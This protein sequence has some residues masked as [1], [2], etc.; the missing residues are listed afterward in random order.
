METKAL[1][2]HTS[3]LENNIHFRANLDLSK[4][5]NPK[6]DSLIQPLPKTT[7]IRQIIS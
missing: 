7:M 5:L 4:T 6:Y 3:S 2:N 1:D